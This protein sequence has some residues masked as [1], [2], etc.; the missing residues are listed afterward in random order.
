MP[1]RHLD[2]GEAVG[3]HGGEAR[4]LDERVSFIEQLREESG[5]VVVINEFNTPD[6]V[7]SFA[8]GATMPHIRTVRLRHPVFEEVPVPG[9]CIG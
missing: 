6:A 9:I 3:C 5:P 2:S 4:R 1:R 8:R 7:E